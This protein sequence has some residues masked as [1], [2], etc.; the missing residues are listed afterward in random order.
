MAKKLRCIWALL[1]MISIFSLTSC[2]SI[3]TNVMKSTLD[4]SGKELN[5]M[6]KTPE[7]GSLLTKN[8]ALVLEGIDRYM[9]GNLML[10][11]S[12]AT[13]AGLKLDTDNIEN[14][15]GKSDDTL[16]EGAGVSQKAAEAAGSET[17]KLIA[18]YLAPKKGDTI[19]DMSIPTTESQEIVIHFHY[20]SD[21]S[22]LI[23]KNGV[24]PAIIVAHGGNYTMGEFSYYTRFTSKIANATKAVVV[25]VDYRLAPEWKF[26]A[27]HDDMYSTWNWLRQH[28]GEYAIDPENI[29]F[30]G[31]SA[32]A[33]LMAG[34]TLRLLQE[35]SPLPKSIVLICPNVSLDS[36]M[37]PSRILFS[38]L[39]GRTFMIPFSMFKSLQESYLSD[40]A[41]VYSPYVSPLVALL[42]LMDLGA[43]VDTYYTPHALDIELPLKHPPTLIQV[44]QIDPLRDEG[45]LYYSALKH[46]GTDVELKLYEG[47]F[48]EFFLL[49]ML[50][51]EADRALE[52]MSRF[53]VEMWR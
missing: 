15:T 7:P 32:G 22:E 24:L 6:R 42:G 30:F 18:S 37:L 41:D 10:S 47:V 31:D 35:Q 4:V 16:L 29:A 2:Q 17:N 26:P 52:D 5:E 38:G 45:V 19:K 51:P 48:H 1:F 44:A 36:T 27:Q 28:G 33:N 50:L 34:L 20:P 8:S 40:P 12:T 21:A 25:F 23:D 14:V 46:F 11:E 53:I 43:D 39:A 3:I 9:G 49:D 13:K